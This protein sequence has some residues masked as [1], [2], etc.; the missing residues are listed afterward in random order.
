MA[1]IV[2]AHIVMACQ[3]E[4]KEAQSQL[5][6]A[7]RKAEALA[8]EIEALRGAKRTLEAKAAQAY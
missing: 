5:V 3:R 6:E 7:A 2:M 8:A 4:N 1:Y